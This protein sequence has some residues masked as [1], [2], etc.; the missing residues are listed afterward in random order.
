M[1]LLS[2]TITPIDERSGREKNKR[3]LKPIGE[4]LHVIVIL[5]SV[6]NAITAYLKALNAKYE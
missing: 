5:N 6:R 3:I 2:K 4:L 1:V